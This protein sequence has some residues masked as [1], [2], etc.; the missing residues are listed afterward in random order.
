VKKDLALTAAAS[1]ASVE[2]ATPTIL[3]SLLLGELALGVLLFASDR[4]PPIL[5]RSLQ[6]FLRF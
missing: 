3:W 1:S 4:L 5:V 6:I 2:I